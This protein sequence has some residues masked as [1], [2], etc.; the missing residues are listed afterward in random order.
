MDISRCSKYQVM[1]IKTQNHLSTFEPDVKVGQNEISYGMVE[2]DESDEGVR[3][4][5]GKS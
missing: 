3:R 1:Y 4:A 5:T 2:K